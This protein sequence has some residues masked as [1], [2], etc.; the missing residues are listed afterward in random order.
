MRA[1]CRLAAEILQMAGK[2]V[3]VQIVAL[4][5]HSCLS[6]EVGLS[7]KPLLLFQ[8]HCKFVQYSDR[9]HRP[10]VSQVMLCQ[11]VAL[12]AAPACVCA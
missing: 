6:L 5:R 2:L 1:A 3:K 10:I 11:E 9:M 8:V 7:C 12:S 4:A